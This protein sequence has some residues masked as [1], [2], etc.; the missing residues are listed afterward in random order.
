MGIDIKSRALQGKPV[1]LKDT[2]CVGC[3]ECIVRCPMEI[4]HLGDLPENKPYAGGTDA[5]PDGTVFVSIHDSLDIPRVND[6]TLD[7]RSVEP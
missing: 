4:L 1:T 6:L 2:P 3:T 5:G 7:E